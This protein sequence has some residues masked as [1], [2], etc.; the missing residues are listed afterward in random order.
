M[1]AWR[2]A[3]AADRPAVP[4]VE[5][6]LDD[7]PAVDPY[8]GKARSLGFLLDSRLAADGVVYAAL[9]L[10]LRV[11]RV[12]DILDVLR[13]IK[14]RRQLQADAAAAEAGPA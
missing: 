2:L 9:A 1:P 3:P 14:N 4:L 7:W 6:S 8:D 11:I 5:R 13:L 10:A 12:G